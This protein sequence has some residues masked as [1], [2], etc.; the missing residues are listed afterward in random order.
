MSQRILVV[1]AGAALDEEGL[2]G[3]LFKNGIENVHRADLLDALDIFSE[4]INDG[5]DAVIIEDTTA[6]GDG[7][8][9]V[10]EMREQDPGQ[11][12]I[13]IDD[14]FRS[15]REA[16]FGFIIPRNKGMLGE[17]LKQIGIGGGV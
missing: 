4:G 7:L 17:V 15:I 2:F 6:H 8:D 9:L 5:W 11:L 1:S 16:E 13:V 10:I 12:V 14:C 3:C